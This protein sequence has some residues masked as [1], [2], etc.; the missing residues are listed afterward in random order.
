MN[1]LE[2]GMITDDYSI[3]LPEAQSQTLGQDEEYCILNGSN[4][5]CG[6]NYYQIMC[7]GNT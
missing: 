7:H 6:V 4:G 5:V 1:V 2:K 3:I